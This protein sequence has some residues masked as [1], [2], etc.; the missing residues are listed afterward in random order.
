MPGGCDRGVGDFKAPKSLECAEIFR[1]IAITDTLGALHTSLSTQLSR[2]AYN[3][4]LSLQV[5]SAH[6]GWIISFIPL[7]LGYQQPSLC[8]VL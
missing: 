6:W 8:L 2:L 3:L 1:I 7:I 4:R 5:S